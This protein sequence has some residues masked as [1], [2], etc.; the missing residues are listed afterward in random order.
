M[1]DYNITLELMQKY[2]LS[3]NEPPYIFFD[4]PDVG[5]CYEIDDEYYGKIVRKKIFKEINALEEF[6]KKLVWMRDNAQKYNVRM[7]LDNYE[8]EDPR[9]MF[10]RNNRPMLIGEMMNIQAYDERNEQKK[11]L[12]PNARILYE[13]GDLLLV[14]DEIKIR[15]L[16][17]ME[18]VNKLKNEVRRKYHELQK[19]VNFYNGNEVELN[20]T[21]LSELVSNTGIN[22]IA[23]VAL[24][25]R[26]NLYKVKLPDETELKALLDETWDLLKTIELN[27]V[28]YEACV[29]V[30]ELRNEIELVDKKIS[31]M[32]ELNEDAGALKIDLMSEFRKINKEF[33]AS[34]TFVYDRF[35]DSKLE[36]VTKKYSAYEMLDKNNLADFLRE[37]LENNDYDELISRFMKVDS[38]V[39]SNNKIVKLPFNEVVNALRVQYNSLAPEEQAMM[40]LSNTN[41]YRELFGYIS[42]IPDFDKIS[43]ENVMS[44]INAEKRMARLKKLCYETIKLR[45]ELP[46]NFNIKQ[47]LFFFINF[48]TFETFIS[49]LVNG[50]KKLMNI[51]KK[52]ILNSDVSLFL[53]KSE[54]LENSTFLFISNNLIEPKKGYDYKTNII[55]S[56][57]VK[58]GVP[59]I[60]CPYY[61]DLGQLESKKKDAIVTLTIKELPYFNIMV[62]KTNL[63][64]SKDDFYVTITDYQAEPVAFEDHQVVHELKY[65]G[66]YLFSKMTVLDNKSAAKVRS[67]LNISTDYRAEIGNANVSSNVTENAVADEVSVQTSVSSSGSDNVDLPATVNNEIVQTGVQD[68]SVVQSSEE[69]ELPVAK[70]VEESGDK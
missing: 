50:L 59:V 10:L 65:V 51:D 48:E 17:E 11:Q 62:D 5:I 46:E 61:V 1:L 57:L 22:E 19:E 13:V 52:M 67:I 68:Q 45:L 27:R 15:Q 3:S 26:Y 38:S 2:G 8:N 55:G 42:S 63:L 54:W 66:K 41:Y 69:I 32:N 4:D 58:C 29:E 37:S 7:V 16:G 21:L 35:V 56:V 64:I 49:C 60:Y 30:K 33:E 39:E 6:L 31:L 12:D 18:I 70:T 25:D 20:L 23:E 53:S 14:Y 40:I 36:N 47:S 44:S 28:Y 43:I 9:I 34:K 24:K